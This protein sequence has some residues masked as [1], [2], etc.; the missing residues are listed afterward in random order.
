MTTKTTKECPYCFS[1]MHWKATRCP[2]CSGELRLCPKC[3]QERAVTTNSK[4]VG[5]VRG[6][7]KTQ[8]RCATCH[9]VIDGPRF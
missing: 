5:L 2:S 1:E 8:T 4:F 9:T 3:H 7:T 6:G